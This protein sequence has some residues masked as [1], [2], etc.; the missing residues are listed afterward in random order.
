MEKPIRISLMVAITFQHELY[1]TNCSFLVSLYKTQTSK[2]GCRKLAL[3]TY[4]VMCFFSLDGQRE[5]IT[6]IQDKAAIIQDNQL[7]IEDDDSCTVI[8]LVEAYIRPLLRQGIWQ[9]ID[10]TKRYIYQ[11][12]ALAE[13]I[14]YVW[15][16]NILR[17]CLGSAYTAKGPEDSAQYYLRYSIQQM[18]EI[19]DTARVSHFLMEYGRSCWLSSKFDTAI[20]VTEKAAR[21][22][23]QIR[24]SA[25]YL[26]YTS[27]LPKYYFESGDFVKSAKSSFKNLELAIQFKDTFNVAYNARYLAKVYFSMGL[28]DREMEAAITALRFGR[29]A[30]NVNTN[31]Q[32]YLAISEAYYHQLQYDSAIAYA[33]KNISLFYGGQNLSDLTLG[34]VYRDVGLIDSALFHIQ[35]FID[36]T[37]KYKLHVWPE[38]Y[39]L[40][41]SCEFINGNFQKATES[42]LNA[43]AEIQPQN[44][45]IF[46]SIY[47]SL[48]SCYDILNQPEKA[49][50]YLKRFMALEDSMDMNQKSFAIALMGSEKETEKMEVQIQ[51]LAE[52]NQL[53]KKLT[54]KEKQQKN[55]LFVGISL[56]A[57]LSSFGFIRYRK[58]R[59]NKSKQALLHERMRI[60]RDLHDEV[61]ATL[62]GIAMYSQLA[63]EQAK[64]S[65]SADVMES[66]DIIQ[67]SSGDMVGKLSD[68][69][70]L[71][72]PE[73]D[74]LQ[75]LIEKL[76]DYCKQMAAV[77]RMKIKIEIT[78]NL[79]QLQ[80]PVEARRNIYLIC[81]EAINNAVKYSFAKKL[82]IGMM[83][84][85]RVL[86]IQITDDGV[87]FDADILSSGNGLKYMNQRARLIDARL[88]VLS[89]KMEGTTIELSYQLSA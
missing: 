28:F 39:L 25:A 3:I 38:P 30:N 2:F 87:G 15:G 77:K 12:M 19:R 49:M 32:A 21:N 7:G 17:R 26:D 4:L 54:R 63:K 76:E 61:G 45:L 18:E 62:S 58:Q 86:Y 44:K 41:G 66:L 23:L 16:I 67:E 34:A 80:L 53:Q 84:R 37:I 9:D 59:E 6:A 69:V 22:A 50:Y 65:H 56:L 36:A 78:P 82:L 47:K 42:F 46:R 10:S 24:D 8:N 81:K 57:V 88:A 31:F 20:Y 35:N 33:W 52:N 14:N 75:K 27:V 89:K 68:I 51:W 1:F 73:N 74:T 43:E 48:S 55:S 11:A 5:S 83:E 71:L 60:S 79:A 13:K 85:D 72:N 40:L 29:N 70:W 64:H